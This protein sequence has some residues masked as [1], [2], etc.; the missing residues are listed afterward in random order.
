MTVKEL[1]AELR[2]VKDQDLT[3]WY[4]YSNGKSVMCPMSRV[5]EGQGYVKLYL[6]E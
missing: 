5:A 3:V 2:Q 1:I 6:G 4:H